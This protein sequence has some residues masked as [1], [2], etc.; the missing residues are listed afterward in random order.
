MLLLITTPFFIVHL[1]NLKTNDVHLQSLN[2]CYCYCYCFCLD[3]SHCDR[4]DPLCTINMTVQGWGRGGVGISWH[5]RA[6]VAVHRGARR[7]CLKERRRR[8]CDKLTARLCVTAPTYITA[9][10]SGI[11]S[12]AWS[13]ASQMCWHRMMCLSVDNVI[14]PKICTAA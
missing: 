14:S 4:M 12:A 1:I 2:Y 11:I 5:C 13:S 6:I 10:V 8:C 9:G 3:T 7:S